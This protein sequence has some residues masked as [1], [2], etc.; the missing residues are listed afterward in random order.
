MTQKPKRQGIRQGIGHRI[1]WIS[2]SLILLSSCE[3]QGI[4]KAPQAVAVGSSS[5]AA[6]LGGGIGVFKSSVYNLTT[7]KC[8]GCHKSDQAPLIADDDVNSAY[9]A[10]KS[11]VSWNDL[12]NSKLLAKIDDGH[13]GPY[14]SG[15]YTAAMANYLST[16]AMAEGYSGNIN[17]PNPGSSG[18]PTPSPTA[19]ASGISVFQTTVYPYA[20]ANCS[21]CHNG[22]QTPNF[23]VTSVNNAYLAAKSVV[24]F[25]APATSK[26]YSQSMNGHC[27]QAVCMT[28][29]TAM[30][31]AIQTWAHAEGF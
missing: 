29:G 26:L 20:L 7:A 15:P 23:A 16:W 9:A 14:C 21:G 24:N 19:G 12:G 31:N 17:S 5:S 13:C 4:N 3:L 18:S 22:S 30:L 2:F 10:A 28:N 8:A 27:G 11:E 25:S 1:G 6:A